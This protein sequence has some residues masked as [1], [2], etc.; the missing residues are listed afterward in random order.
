MRERDIIFAAKVISAIFNPFYLPVVGLILL[1]IFSYLKMLPWNYKLTVITLVY[2]FTVLLPTF[3]IYAYRRYQGWTLIELGV[4]ERRMVPYVISIVC[5]G[6][7]YYVME[8]FHIPHFMGSIVVA[9]LVVQVVCG[10]INQW[11]K[12]S[13]HSAAIGGVMGALWAFALVFQF[14]PV[15]WFCLIMV[16]AGLMGTSRMILRQ[17]TLQQVIVGFFVGAICAHFSIVMI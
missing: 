8:V 7:C 14:N 12:I 6:L 10:I 17:H 11:W 16:I 13:T 3:L 4:K 2:L 15:W 1:F 5:Y 9:A